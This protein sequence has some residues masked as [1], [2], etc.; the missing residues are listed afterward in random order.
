ML[1]NLFALRPDFSKIDKVFASHLHVDHVGGFMPFHIGSW[2][3][4][5]YTPIH[6]YGPSGAT[7]ELG[8]KAFVDG[9]KK[10]Y[11]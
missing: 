7:P 3:S 11:A 6:L 10:G 8:T 1:S 5:R 9:M 4:S 2:L